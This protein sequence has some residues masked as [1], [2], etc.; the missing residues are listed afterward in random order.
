MLHAY[1]YPV[2][3][4]SQSVSSRT[5]IHRGRGMWRK[6]TRVGQVFQGGGEEEAVLLIEVVRTVSPG[7]KHGALLEGSAAFPQVEER[8]RVQTE[9][10][11]QQKKGMTCWLVSGKRE[12]HADWSAEKGNDM[13]IGQRES[14]VEVAWGGPDAGGGHDVGLNSKVM[15]RSTD[16]LLSAMERQW[17]VLSREVTRSGLFQNNDDKTIQNNGRC[18][19]PDLLCA[20]HHSYTFSLTLIDKPPRQQLFPTSVVKKV[21][22]TPSFEETLRSHR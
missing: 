17:R 2:T 10:R 5:L 22:G 15:G 4:G 13:L 11:A 9:D 8:K 18:H 12:R 21:V 19:F 6:R 3:Q 20:R 1:L 16:I 7:D 14:S